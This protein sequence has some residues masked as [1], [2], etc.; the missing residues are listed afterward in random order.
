MKKKQSR[1][2]K[3][4]RQKKIRIRI[5]LFIPLLLIIWWFN[6]FT[7]TVN[8]VCFTDSRINDVITIV[9]LTDLHGAKFG[10]KNRTLIRKIEEQSPDLIVVTGDMY[11]NITE[12]SGRKTALELMQYLGENFEVYYIN[13]EHD[14]SDEGFY[15]QL[16]AS[17]VHVMNY[18]DE[19]ITVKNTKIHLYGINNVYYSDTFDLSNAF[20]PDEENYSILLAHSSYFR[21]F[22]DFGMDL[23]ICGDTH[24]EMFRLPVIGALYDGNTIL[25]DRQGIYTK[26]T[27]TLGD[28]SLFISSGLG[29]YPLPVRFCNR[30]EIAVIEL[31]PKVQ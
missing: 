19:I 13:G 8:D 28:S 10:I 31:A 7:L 24:G 6:N 9:Q 20:T 4:M 21:R 3:L 2:Q 12:N 22:A 14:G 1:K 25:P 18:K 11:S 26:G 30:P 15:S 27:Y 17:G 5:S 16:E 29:N 23:S